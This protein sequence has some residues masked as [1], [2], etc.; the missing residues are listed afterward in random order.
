MVGNSFVDE[1]LLLAVRWQVVVSYGTWKRVVYLHL[2][3]K[4]PA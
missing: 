3:S 4:S 2:A 1:L